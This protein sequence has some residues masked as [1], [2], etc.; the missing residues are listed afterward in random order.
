MNDDALS[1]SDCKPVYETLQKLKDGKIKPIGLSRSTIYLCVEALLLEGYQVSS[2]AKLLDKSDRTIRR[3][4]SELRRMNALE[5]SP[6]LTRV[7]LGEFLL[8]ARN[9]YSRL[10][11]LARVKDVSPS[12]KAKTEFLAWRVSRELIEM[13]FYVGF[14]IDDTKYDAETSESER[15]ILE[16]KLLGENRDLSVDERNEMVN[17]I[18][19]QIMESQ[20]RIDKKNFE[21]NNKEEVK[22]EGEPTKDSI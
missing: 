5:A 11:Q 6:S 12:E 17:N 2:I 21:K 14:L 16:E 13:L 1:L 7:L 19:R 18:F 9:Q 8:N 10:K 22:K 3:Y 20:R 15:N 4:V